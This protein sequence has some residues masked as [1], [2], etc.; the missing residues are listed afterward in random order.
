[1][2]GKRVFV[3]ALSQGLPEGTYP[4][5]LCIDKDGGVWSARCVL[6][7]HPCADWCLLIIVPG[8]AGAGPGLSGTP[9]RGRWMLRSCFQRRSTSL[10]ARSEVSRP[11][12]LQFMLRFTSRIGPNNDQLYVTTAHCGACGGDATRQAEYPDS[13]NLFVV[14]LSGVFVGGEWRFE[15]AG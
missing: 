11:S 10:P 9:E 7:E 3:D 6:T 14:D 5:G 4:D 1:M 8:A 13:G 15:F 2:S 12:R